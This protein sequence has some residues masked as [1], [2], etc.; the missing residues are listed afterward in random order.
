MSPAAE[1]LLVNLLPSTSIGRVSRA[2][3]R[4]WVL[5][6]SPGLFN[7]PA[8]A[9]AAAAHPM[10]QAAAPRAGARASIR[11]GSDPASAS[12]SAAMVTHAASTEGRRCYD[13]ANMG[14]SSDGRRGP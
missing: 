9:Q 7:H 14:Q 4:R 6:T 3:R 2:A 1:A 12:G 5:L 10:V 11:S 8:V 13:Q